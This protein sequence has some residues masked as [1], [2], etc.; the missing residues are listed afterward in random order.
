MSAEERIYKQLENISSSIIK[1]LEG[2]EKEL[3]EYIEVTDSR[4]NKLEN[5]IQRLESLADVSSSGLVK[6]IEKSTSQEKTSELSH[7]AAKPSISSPVPQPNEPVPIKA[8]LP[9]SPVPQPKESILTKTELPQKPISQPKVTTP[10]PQPTSTTTTPIK[11][12]ESQ[13]TSGIPPVP[14]PP[15]FKP[16]LKE[17]S[18]KEETVVPQPKIAEPTT[19]EGSMATNL[20]EKKKKENDKDKDDLMSALKMIDSL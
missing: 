11:T 15:S 9:Q 6:T 3:A 19:A 2:L 14:I 7:I 17:E 10:I 18:P 13:A 12:T 4:L 5:K 1:A 20:E 16:V 8:E